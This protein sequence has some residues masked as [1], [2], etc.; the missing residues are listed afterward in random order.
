MNIKNFPLDD[1]PREKAMMYG[2]NSL[3]DIELIAILLGSG[4]KDNNVIQISANLLSETGGLNGL[5]KSNYQALCKIKGIKK[6]KALKLASLISIY[7][8]VD[9]F[10]EE[11]K[12]TIE[13]ILDKYEKQ[14]QIDHQ[15][16]TV[17]VVLDKQNNIVHDSLI[18]LGTH[19]SMNL[20]PKDIF[21]E[22]YLN[23][24]KRF[25][26][27]HTHPYSISYPSPLD[28]AETKSIMMDAKRFSFDFI[29]H[30]VIGTDG[31]IEVSRFIQ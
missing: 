21:R 12:E 17:V 29:E 19:A 2:I 11:N 22:I 27:I 5:I 9:S 4:T 28:I 7:Q 24:G 25:Y 6:A 16:R 20:A 1:R 31:Y 8:R 10:R 18:A 23:N 14:L 15:E 13:K 30:Y 26:L 3:S